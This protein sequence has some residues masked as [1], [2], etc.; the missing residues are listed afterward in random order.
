MWSNLRSVGPTDRRVCLSWLVALNEATSMHIKAAVRGN[1]K[2][3]DAQAEAAL[4]DVK[5]LVSTTDAT[6]KL[7]ADMFTGHAKSLRNT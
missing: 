7:F 4:Q 5:V 1:I 3:L 6:H 2:T